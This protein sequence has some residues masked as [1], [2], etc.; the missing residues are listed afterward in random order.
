MNLVNLGGIDH[1]TGVYYNYVETYGGGQGASERQDGMDGVHTH[2]TNTR[3]TPVEVIESSY[4]FRIDRYGL[5][6][7]SEGAGQYRGGLGMTREIVLLGEEAKF[8]L[9]GD[10]KNLAPWGVFGG[11]PAGTSSC[12]ITHADGAQE[13]TSSKVTMPL[14]KGD[15]ITVVTP[16]GGGWGDPRLRDPESVRRDVHEG[17]VS[18]K[19]AQEIYGLKDIDHV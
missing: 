17:F 12:V 16:G 13:S 18:L 1:R 9:S 10:R 5:V 2:M 3:N 19:R 14:Q 7:D 4:P 8:S 11:Q 6:P 15:K